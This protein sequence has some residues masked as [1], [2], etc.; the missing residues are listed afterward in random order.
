MRRRS[1]MTVAGQPSLCY[2]Y[3]ATNRLTGIGQGTCPVGGNAVAIGYDSIGRRTSLTL[4]EGVISQYSYDTDSHLTRIT[5]S[6]G[7]QILGDLAYSY[8]VA[9]RRT[10]VG[11]SFARTGIPAAIANAVYNADNQLTQWGTANLTYDPNGNLLNDGINSYTWDVRNHLSGINGGS[12]AS[13]QYDAFGRRIS[14][15]VN[16]VTT[17]SLYDQKNVVQELSGITP[18]AN[19]LTGLRTDE[20]FSRTDTGGARIFLTDAIGSTLAL[21]DSTGAIQT[22]YTYEPFGKTTS[23]GAASFNTFEFTGRENDGTGLYF[24]RARYQSPRLLRFVSEDP[25]GFRGGIN[26]FS[27]TAD[28]P[29]NFTD[30]CG[31]TP[32]GGGDP[33]TTSTSWVRRWHLCAK[34]R[35]CRRLFGDFTTVQSHSLPGLSDNPPAVRRGLFV[36]VH[37]CNYRSNA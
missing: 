10:Q 34:Y 28:N 26:L 32:N 33:P 5:Y 16:G 7:S 8:D 37:F 14:K 17:G 15:S 19:V 2:T 12:T 23:S 31:L 3:D 4:P 9:G 24:Y 21:T 18:T 11:G 29:V 35:V 36:C 22:Q 1:S 27:Y 20:I 30:A 6:N 13:F 25:I